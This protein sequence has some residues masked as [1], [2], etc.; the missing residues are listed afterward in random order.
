MKTNRKNNIE[1]HVTFLGL[2]GTALLIL[3]LSVVGVSYIFHAQCSMQ[4]TLRKTLEKEVVKTTREMNLEKYRWLQMLTPENL[5]NIREAWMMDMV[6]APDPRQKATLILVEHNGELATSIHYHA[7][8][9]S[10]IKKGASPFKYVYQVN[11]DKEK[12]KQ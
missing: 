1:N 10:A 6:K 3:T 5:E 11:N 7:E 12:S 8:T 2:H 4:R 9:Y